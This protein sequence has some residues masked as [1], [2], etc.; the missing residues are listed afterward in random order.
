MKYAIM[1]DYTTFTTT[2]VEFPEGKTWADVGEWYIKW[3]KLNVL[4]N[5]ETEYQEFELDEEHSSDWKRPSASEIRPV[6]DEGEIDWDIG[7]L[8]TA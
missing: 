1:A 3:H 4:F 6:S 2:H 7:T 5:G 8:A